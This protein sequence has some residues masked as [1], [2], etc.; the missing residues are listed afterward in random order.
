[1]G[2]LKISPDKFATLLSQALP[3]VI[4]NDG[5]LERFAGLLESLDRLERRLTPEEKPSKFCSLV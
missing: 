1:M 4:E 2:T 3:K 5:E